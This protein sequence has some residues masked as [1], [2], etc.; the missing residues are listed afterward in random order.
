MLHVSRSYSLSGVSLGKHLWLRGFM[1]ISASF[2]RTVSFTARQATAHRAK[3]REGILSVNDTRSRVMIF[4]GRHI[5]D[6]DV[7]LSSIQSSDSM[8]DMQV[9]DL[10]KH[11][12]KS[13]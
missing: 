13:R 3:R 10:H 6:T 7:V 4:S 12:S 11:N 2:G 8:D 1:P 9:L 5:D